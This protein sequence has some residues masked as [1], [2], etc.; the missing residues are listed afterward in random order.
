MLFLA[1]G[2]SQT[3][4]YDTPLDT[5]SCTTNNQSDHNGKKLTPDLH[6]NKTQR[7]GVEIKPPFG[8]NRKIELLASTSNKIWVL[9]ETKEKIT[10]VE[11]IDWRR[12]HL[13]SSSHKRESE[14]HQA[15]HSF[16]I[17]C[18]LWVFHNR[19]KRLKVYHFLGVFIVMHLDST[20]SPI[21]IRWTQC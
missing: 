19:I 12:E 15:R 21:L 3:W 5:W 18:R 8:C 4:F 16:A 9:L 13:V 10:A 7:F 1:S 20:P 14:H 2:T 6:T 17:I 11:D